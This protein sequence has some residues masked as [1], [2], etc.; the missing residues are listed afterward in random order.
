MPLY[1]AIVFLPFS[2]AARDAALDAKG[3]RLAPHEWNAAA[4]QAQ[5][6]AHRA[7]LEKYGCRTQQINDDGGWVRFE[8]GGGWIGEDI[9]DE[10]LE[11]FNGCKGQLIDQT[12]ISLKLAL[13]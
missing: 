9:A 7:F 5:Q 2:Y 11:T 13:C 8:I 1:S 6:P 3:Y 10:F 12:E 4:V